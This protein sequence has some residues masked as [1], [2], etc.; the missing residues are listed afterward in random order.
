[1][2]GWKDGKLFKIASQGLQFSVNL[3]AMGYG[4][5]KS[6]K[7]K[8][9]CEIMIPCCFVMKFLGF[10][11]IFFQIIQPSRNWGKFSDRYLKNLHQSEKF[12]MICTELHRTWF[13]RASHLGVNHLETK[14][15]GTTFNPKMPN[16]FTKK[17]STLQ[18]HLLFWQKLSTQMGFVGPHALN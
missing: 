11:Y 16:R 3:L 5:S 10:R 15:V 2:V 13:A 18:A 9:G 1:M 6:N 17:F 12:Q 14:S 7:M 4:I 8:V